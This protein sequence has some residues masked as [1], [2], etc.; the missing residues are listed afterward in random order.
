MIRLSLLI[1]FRIDYYQEMQESQWK[2]GRY[3]H[4]TKSQAFLKEFIIVNKD[5][6]ADL[7]THAEY[8]WSGREKT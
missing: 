6:I 7:K 3:D 4:I 8:T 2:S 1:S 5:K